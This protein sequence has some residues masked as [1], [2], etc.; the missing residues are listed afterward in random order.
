M[1]NFLR[2]TAAFC[3]SLSLL[4][5]LAVTASA[6]E[7]L[8][9][10][11]HDQT[12]HL[13]KD[14][15]L[16][17]NVFWSSAYSDL[18]TEN[19]I[20]YEPNRTVK[21]LVMFGDTLTDRATVSSAARQLER[22]GYRVVAGINGDFYNTSTGL[23]IGIVVANGELRSSD[24]GYYAIGFK[25]DGSAILGKPGI[26]LNADLGYAALDPTNDTPTQIIRKIA[27]INKARV[28]S[29]G[30]YL[31][32][33]DFNSR[34]TTGNTEPGVDVICT[35]KSGSFSIGET[36]RLQVEDVIEASGP[37]A[38]REDQ[39][40]LSV[41]AKSNDYFVNALRYLPIGS[42]VKVDISAASRSWEDVQYAVGALYSLVEDGAVVSG[43]PSGVSPRTAIGQKKDGTLV[44]YTIDGRKSGHS[45]GASLTQVA[46]RLIELGCVTAVCLDGGGSTTLAVTEPDAITATVINMPSEGSERSVTNQI[47]LVAD[48]KPSEKLGHF[49]VKADNQYVLAGSRVGIS[50][51]AVDTT[52][53]P[54]KNQ[55]FDL[56]A[57]D[58]ELEDGYLITPDYDC[59]ITVT[60]S[61]KGK[62]GSTVV[63]VV[64]CP[65]SITVRNSN[66]A[67]VTELTLSPGSS[68]ALTA[69]AQYKHMT[70][71][72][73]Q[74]AFRWKLKGDDIGEI[75]SKGV[76]TATA[77]GEATL[78]VS[79]GGEKTTVNITVSRISLET[80]DDF[81][82]N[83]DLFSGG[84]N[85]T[86]SHNTATDLVR[87]GR[88]SAR[89]DYELVPD[90]AYV[91]QATADHSKAAV[92]DTLNLWVYGDGSENRLS[93]LYTGDSGILR[94]HLTTLN[95]TGWKQISVYIPDFRSMNGIAVEANGYT[96]LD[97]N[98]ELVIETPTTPLTGTIYLDQIVF[99]YSGLVDDDVPIIT[100]ELDEDHWEVTAE[101][102]DLTDGILPE[103]AISVSINGYETDD[104]SYRKGQ[105]TVELP[106]VDEEE[107]W[108][109]MRVTITAMDA[110]GNITRASVDVPA[111][112][113]TRKFTDVD[114]NWGD[115]LYTAGITNGYEDGTYR[116][117]NLITRAQFSAL[118]YRYLRLD[119]ADYADVVLPFA[120]LDQIPGY[121]LPA[122]RAL[123]TEGAINGS[124]GKDG[125]LY[126][127]PYAS[128]T[129]A[130]ATA[131]IG[132]TLDKGSAVADLNYT[133]AA[134][135]P[136]YAVYY[137]QSTVAQGA[138]TG[139]ADGTLRPN[140][141]ITRGDVAKILYAFL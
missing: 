42:T 90:A 24:G 91:A 19:F 88:G 80:A 3:L 126:F 114:A 136:N 84:P 102:E 16:S 93:L 134:S 71:A 60:A 66:G 89:L 48:N 2:R 51:A 135:V 86:V 92:Y 62:E 112:D 33:Y 105:L 119:E 47:F 67:A 124:V 138:I 103:K 63:H 59:D 83:V 1:K 5:S 72:A 75:S 101:I 123:Y 27:G 45:V 110:S 113:P 131:M 54:M 139:Y 44:F 85:L 34:H 68:V 35:V 104:F 140:H 100:A 12:I 125:R 77:S 46:Q 70:L 120:D 43:L 17:T 57:D 21:P 25:K 107:G 26:T 98:G 118:L 15:E 10:D 64:E 106:E 115:F 14:T 36:L 109:A 56:D 22:E 97:E 49:Y 127:N 7:A 87:M 38:I 30:I 6:S 50:A 40:V 121:A 81:E 39:V 78:T 58:G 37:T 133:D 23:P 111:S 8:G 99:S 79:A 132:R 76:F 69:S 9:E 95:F 117:N 130:Q 82:K 55:T 53:I 29:G 122:V 41:N 137:L 28:S 141:P 13:N 73:D 31:Y 32:T 116:P 128:L 94:A 65:D 52:F 4:A 74:N 129:R 96:Y 11:L 108:E 20:T 18:R 61:R